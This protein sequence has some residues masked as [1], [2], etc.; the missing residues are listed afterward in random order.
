MAGKGGSSGT[1][2]AVSMLYD[3]GE[4][5]DDG[6]SGFYGFMYGDPKPGNL[7]SF[8]I[9]DGFLEAFVRGNRTKFLNANDYTNL[10]V[11]DSLDD[12]KM[13]LAQTEYGD[14]LANEP[15][16]LA[17]TTIKDKCIEKFVNE[18]NYIR[19]NATEPLFTFLDYIRYGYMIDNVI[20]V[21]TGA[22]HQRDTAELLERCHPLG[23][24]R[25]IGSLTT[26]RSISELYKHVLVDTPIGPYILQC[27]SEQDFDPDE[28]NVE[29]IRNKLYKAYLEDFNR[30][31]QYLG[32]ATAELMSELLN[33]EADRRSITITLN[34]FGTEL[35][36]DDRA[37]MYPSLGLLHPAG[38][39]KLARADDA[40]Q[41]REA[42]SHILSYRKLFLDIGPGTEKSLE[43]AFFEYEVELN[44]S[45]FDTQMGYA[46]FYAYV[47]LK[48]QEIRN[49]VWV[50]ECVSQ[51]QKSKIHDAVIQIF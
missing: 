26:C 51:G 11:C 40:E 42:V 45:A 30:F 20:L 24:F 31:C 7:L 38:V 22:L 34:S 28:Q 18:F 46:L 35:G 29:V 19:S 49:V 47:K 3:S 37:T 44:R 39:I 17:T 50:A 33:F 12:V 48:E 32:G 27:M 43:D 9:E 16:P 23:M 6:R 8:N 36:K 14:F 5:V 4:E 21:I 13:H 1:S 15:S 10:A 41:V 25:T 2:S